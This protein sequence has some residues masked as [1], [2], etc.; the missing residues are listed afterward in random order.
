MDPLAP[1]T[2]IIS[3]Q[4]NSKTAREEQQR[5]HK[6]N[7]EYM[8]L[9]HMYEMESARKSA[10]MTKQ[11]LIAAGLSPALMS[12]GMFA[13]ATAPTAP[14]APSPAPSRF[15]ITSSGIGDLLAMTNLQA[16]TDNIKAN[17][18]KT[19]LENEKTNDENVTAQGLAIMQLEKMAADLPDSA[20]EQKARLEALASLAKNRGSLAALNNFAHMLDEHESYN[21]RAIQNRL[22]KAVT[23]YQLEEKHGQ[24]GHSIIADL[25]SLPSAQFAQLWNS[26]MD[27]LRHAE[28][29][30]GQKDMS[31]A[32]KN[33]K[34]EQ[35]KLT[36]EQIANLKEV[37]QRI[38]DTNLMKIAEDVGKGTENPWKLL[39]AISF[40]L[41]S[42]TS[43][44][45][46]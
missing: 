20:I 44:S 14:S 11:G 10:Q 9:S 23:E 40:L 33:L 16:Q 21:A 5:A 27:L 30:Q 13:P 18:E 4:M 43:V 1:V 24:D 32:E 25:A 22:Q 36:R 17:T 7:K 12:Q 34:L 2:A 26:S 28:W 45:I 42:N 8:S 35:T 37:T 15:N 39:A 31:D 46:R 3:G 41:F 6:Y 29:L 19:K 38:K